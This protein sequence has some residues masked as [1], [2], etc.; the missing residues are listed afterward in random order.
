V[1]DDVVSLLV[2]RASLL[3]ID[4]ALLEH[5]GPSERR[6]RA[7]VRHAM[8]AVVGA[9][10]AWLAMRGRYHGSYVEKCKR[11]RACRA[12]D[13]ALAAAYERAIAFRLEPRYEALASASLEGLVAQCREVV[14]P[15][16]LA[17]EARALGR[18]RITWEVFGRDAPGAVSRA[19]W[20]RP[21]RWP[22]ELRARCR[23]EAPPTDPH[24]R[25]RLALPAVLHE[26]ASDALAPLARSVLGVAP[27]ADERTLR[28][29][30][31]ACWANDVDPSFAS[32]MR[33]LGARPE[34]WIG[35]AS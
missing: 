6:D 27:A 16:H 9:G 13:P 3:V 25:L 34:A 15:V 20:S 10:D 24:A 18:D 28:Q 31:L 26:G 29:A 17:L 14:A 8:K 5:E 30:Y 21:T 19:R 22:A 33:A 35:G 12:A 23:G 11:L 4:Q 1:L 2:N 7:I 32:S